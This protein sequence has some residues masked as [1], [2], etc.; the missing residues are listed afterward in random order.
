MDN[1]REGIGESIHPIIGDMTDDQLDQIVKSLDWI[2][3]NARAEDAAEINS[4]KSSLDVDK[5]LINGM[6]REYLMQRE[7]IKTLT[8]PDCADPDCEP[9]AARRKNAEVV[10]LL[11][12][13][14]K[15]G[16]KE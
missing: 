2:F 1:L 16:E 6:N 9:C 14:V 10:R 13:P 5:E 8:T 4:L 11:W 15:R 7:A 12:T 3:Q